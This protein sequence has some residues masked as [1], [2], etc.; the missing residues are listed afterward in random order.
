MQRNATECKRVQRISVRPVQR[1]SHCNPCRSNS[2]PVCATPT[3][4]S[5]WALSFSP[6]NLRSSASLCL[7]GRCSGYCTGVE[8]KPRW[9]REVMP[10][11]LHLEY[12]SLSKCMEQRFACWAPNVLVGSRL[13]VVA[14]LPF[15]TS[16]SMN[17]HTSSHMHA[18][19]DHMPLQ[20]IQASTHCVDTHV[21]VTLIVADHEL[22]W[23]LA[24]SC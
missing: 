4:C 5:S 13:D 9:C 19:H 2:C 16:V 11:L 18:C 20:I 21:I 10:T 23:S 7:G 12:M 1:I 22:L 6:R 14:P 24:A 8:Y 17:I 3:S 15:V